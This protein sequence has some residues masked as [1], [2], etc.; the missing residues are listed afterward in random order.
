MTAMTCGWASSFYSGIASITGRSVDQHAVMS[1]F[2]V[3]LDDSDVEM[4]LTGP[5]WT[6]IAF[7]IYELI[8]DDR[9]IA[10]EAHQSFHSIRFRVRSADRLHRI[11][12]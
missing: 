6:Q 4:N 3:P 8:H 12:L 11:R 5:A 1:R 2:F 10:R 9:I 7:H